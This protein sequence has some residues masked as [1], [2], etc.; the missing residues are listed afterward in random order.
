MKNSKLSVIIPVY[1]EEKIVAET[2]KGLKNELNKLDLEYEIIVVNDASTDK[3]KEILE[4]ITDI[5]II[6]HPYNKGYGASLKTGIGKAKFNNL[7]FFDA[8]GQHKTEHISDMLKYID[9]FD[10]I[11]GARIGYKGPLI[12]Q[13]GKR[14]LHYLA[15]YLTQQKI[16]DLNCGFRIVK[17]EPILRFAHLLCDGFSFSTTAILLF[18][19]EGLAVK[20]VPVRINKRKGKSKVKPRHAFDALIVI[21]RTIL[22]SSPLRIFLPISFLLFLGTLISGIYDI[23]FRPFN[24]TDIT[25]VLFLSS[26]LIFFFGLLADQLAAIRKELKK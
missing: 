1:N 13:P 16:P 25:I 8:D 7:L 15:N 22:L 24:L 6:N 10:L 26:L 20:Y 4:K 14:V 23:F 18:I 9:D 12:R 21:L 17:K 3:T 19:T 5:Q 2:I 11:V